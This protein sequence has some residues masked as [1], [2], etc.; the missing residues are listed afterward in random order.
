MSWREDYRTEVDAVMKMM[1]KWHR[2]AS[3]RRM[4]MM[5]EGGRRRRRREGEKSE[6]C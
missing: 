4:L 3:L 1:I 2:R 5:W 6:G